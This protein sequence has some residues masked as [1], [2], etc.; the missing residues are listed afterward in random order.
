MK[1]SELGESLEPPSSMCDVVEW[2]D[3]DDP[4]NIPAPPVKSISL[5]RN[6]ML[7]PW[8]LDRLTWSADSDTSSIR[9]S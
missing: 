7:S 1:S 5:A 4:E 8:K 9:T 3:N 2:I 6:V